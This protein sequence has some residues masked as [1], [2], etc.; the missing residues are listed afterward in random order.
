M[1]KLPIGIQTFEKIRENS[2]EYVYVDKTQE[3]YNLV[4]TGS[5]YFLSRPRRFGKSLLC[6]TLVSLFE[7]RKELFEGLWIET[8]DWQ[9]KKHPVIHISFAR[10]MRKTPDDLRIYLCK[11]LVLIGKKYGNQLPES[12]APGYLLQLLVE[13][14]AQQNRVVIIIDEYDKP[15]LDHITNVSVARQMREILREFYEAIKDLDQYLSLVFITGVTKFSK[16]S[17]FSGMNNLDDVTFDEEAATLCGFTYDDLKDQF[18]PWI[19]RLADRV[20]L[21]SEQTIEQMQIW[22]N[23]YRFDKL[24]AAFRVYNPFSLLHVLKKR[25]FANYWFETGTPTFLLTLI[26]EKN[27]PAIEMNNVRVAGSDMKTYEVDN[28]DLYVLL[29]QTGYLTIVDYDADSDN[30]TLSYPC[31]EVAQSLIKLMMHSMTSMQLARVNDY[32][33]WFRLALCKGDI[34]YFCKTL[35]Q[36]FTEI[37][38]TIQIGMEKYYQTV[39]FIV[40]RL[41]TRQVYAEVATNI[42]RIDA[43]IEF[44]E[45]VVIIEFKFNQDLAVAIKQIKEKGYADAYR[46]SDKQLIAV[47]L[48]FDIE[49]RNVSSDWIIENL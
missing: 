12:D 45:R 20:K 43:V 47:G 2:G 46:S 44:E 27:Y 15:I 17:I 16:T 18:G 26:E 33:A 42:G 41:L 34:E 11:A 39:F 37:P 36:F 29:Q 3:I 30:Y 31:R 49:K 32:V 22:Y 13:E 7:G 4:S 35:Q 10:I 48:N 25:D 5:V 21:T 8:S 1:K 6:S 24:G 9:W 28:I 14:L 38:Y 23:G 19:Q 40:C